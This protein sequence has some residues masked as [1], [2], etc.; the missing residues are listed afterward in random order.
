MFSPF[1]ILRLDFW[2][3]IEFFESVT[4]ASRRREWDLYL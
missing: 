3:R 2:M 4:G 1:V